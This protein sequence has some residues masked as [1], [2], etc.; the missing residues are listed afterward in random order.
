MKEPLLGT[1]E[2]ST[3]K[4]QPGCR[5]FSPRDPARGTQEFWRAWLRHKYD[6]RFHRWINRRAFYRDGM[7]A[8]FSFLIGP[9]DSASAKS[10]EYSRW[11]SPS[12]LLSRAN[13]TT[14]NNESFQQGIISSTEVE[15]RFSS[16][17]DP[18][19]CHL[20]PS[21]FSRI[22]NIWKQSQRS[23]EM[24]SAWSTYRTEQI[25]RKGLIYSALLSG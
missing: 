2:V 3:L 5:G 14:A 19:P 25:D 16:S 7:L 17:N 15:K 22:P 21:R 11:A 6:K 1:D 24:I 12:S 10:R 9:R 4:N 13:C 23:L 8:L 18:K 20:V